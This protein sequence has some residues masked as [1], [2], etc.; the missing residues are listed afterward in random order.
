MVRTMK[1][2]MKEKMEEIGRKS[3][4]GKCDCINPHHKG[5]I[6]VAMDYMINSRMD[7]IKEFQENLFLLPGEPISSIYPLRS[8]ENE[9]LNLKVTRIKLRDIPNCPD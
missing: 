3:P 8:F 5:V 2:T 7:Q 4:F 1:R 9:I 6:L